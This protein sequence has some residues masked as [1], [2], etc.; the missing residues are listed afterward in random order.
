MIVII[1]IVSCFIIFW[2]STGSTFLL[3]LK[4]AYALGASIVFCHMINKTPALKT[5]LNP[6]SEKNNFSKLATPGK[7]L[8]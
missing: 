8:N 4:I 7:D 1:M 5:G 6:P 2:P 3:V